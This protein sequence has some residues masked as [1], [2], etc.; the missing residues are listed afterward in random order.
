[1]LIL[2]DGGEFILVHV[3]PELGN[4]KN[5]FI[6]LPLFYF[7]SHDVLKMLPLAAI[8]AAA[9]NSSRIHLCWLIIQIITTV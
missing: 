3:T 2:D 1:M 5:L 9:L 8:G 6:L 7:L 4:V